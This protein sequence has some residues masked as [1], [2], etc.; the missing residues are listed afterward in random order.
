MIIIVSLNSIET[1]KHTGKCLGVLL[2]NY[3][4]MMSAA[5]VEELKPFMSMICR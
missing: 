1:T 2:V 4:S 5:R 3:Q